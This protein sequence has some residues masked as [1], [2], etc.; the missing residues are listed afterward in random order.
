MKKLIFTMMGSAVGLGAFAQLPVSTTPE[1]KKVILEE[2]TG[3]HCPACPAGH[4][5]AGDIKKNAPNDVFLINIHTGGYAVPKAGEIDLRTSFGATIAGQTGLTGYPAGVIDRRN[6]PGSEQGSVS[7]ILS[8]SRSNWA[9]AANVVLAESSYVNVACEATIDT[10]SR[11]MIV[12]VEAYFTGTGAPTAM[13]LNVAL[14]QDHIEGV[15]SGS[16]AN[17]ANVLP[18]GK[19]SHDHALRHMITGQ[20]GEVVKTTDQGA[21]VKRTYVYTIPTD[22][23]GVPVILADL[24]I[25]AFIAEGQK[26]IISG[27]DGPITLTKGLSYNAVDG[28]ASADHAAQTDLCDPAF[29][30]KGIYKNNSAMAVD[31]FEVSYALNGS[32]VS[33]IV[34]GTSVA[35]GATYTHT[36][37]AIT[38]PVGGNIIS[39]GVSTGAST[40]MIDTLLTN[41]AS[42]D[43]M[44][45]YMP[46]ASIGS[47]YTWDFESATIGEETW[48]NAINNP[49][50]NFSVVDKTIGASLPNNLG[51][52]AASSNSFLFKLQDMNNL[53]TSEFITHKIDLSGGTNPSLKFDYA[54]RQR[55]SI[56]SDGIEVFASADCGVTWTSVFNKS[57]SAFATEAASTA[58]DFYPTSAQWK[59]EYVD[60]SAFQQA[61]VIIKFVVTAG[62]GGHSLYVDNIGV[63]KTLGL[64]AIESENSLAVYPN[65]TTGTATVSFELTE[66]TAVKMDVLNAMGSLVFSNG[67]KTMNSGSQAIMFDGTELPNGIYFINLTVGENVITK[68]VS[69]IR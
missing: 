38:L 9:T 62:F 51:G 8:T 47:T 25:V 27:N 11:L 28:A 41:N 18:N 55:I 33:E 30:P 22:I 35:S 59:T 39:Y 48:T 57:G 24:E 58:P 64:N 14:T 5:V 19:Y 67:T 3:I 15:Q 36:F 32:P 34:N 46:S 2:Y 16:A 13:N 50:A 63:D 31:T 20:W 60:L 65:P 54:Y 7:G 69:L 53:S 49:S 6:F 40:E 66:A 43:D 52:Y 21:T 17:P 56:S 23:A 12:K 45:L 4:K 42:A 68:K 37:P 29:T 61:D 10:V 1:N 44:V 26:D